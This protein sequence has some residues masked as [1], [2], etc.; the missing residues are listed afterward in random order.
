MIAALNLL[1]AAASARACVCCRE[2]WPAKKGAGDAPAAGTKNFA[3]KTPAAA[4][5]P[6][7]AEFGMKITLSGAGWKTWSQ[8]GPEKTRQTEFPAEQGTQSYKEP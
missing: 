4:L 7:V 8:L 1:I 6:A 3:F 5:L 2:D